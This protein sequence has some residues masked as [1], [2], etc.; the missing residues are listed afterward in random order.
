MKSVSHNENLQSNTNDGEA[1]TVETPIKKNKVGFHSNL[2][3][4]ETPNMQLSASKQTIADIDAEELF[5]NFSRIV[6]I[7]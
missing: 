2:K 4:A 6:S 1:N 7:S 3:T 5:N